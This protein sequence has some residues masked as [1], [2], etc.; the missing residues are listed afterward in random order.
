M[1][2]VQNDIPWCLPLP[3]GGFGSV[4]ISLLANALVVA[5]AVAFA[6]AYCVCQPLT[7]IKI[8]LFLLCRFLFQ[9]RLSF[10]AG[11]ALVTGYVSGLTWAMARNEAT[12]V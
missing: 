8:T 2:Q 10:V 4:G 9:P 1:T 7:E 11:I 6:V 12:A 5:F 3:T